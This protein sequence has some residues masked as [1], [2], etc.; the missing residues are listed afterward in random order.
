MK[1]CDIC[2][3]SRAVIS[4]LSVVCGELKTMVTSDACPNCFS[5]FSEAMIEATIS[6]I[7]KRQERENEEEAKNA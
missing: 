2:R 5:I 3:N 6:A 4:E 7:R 1:A